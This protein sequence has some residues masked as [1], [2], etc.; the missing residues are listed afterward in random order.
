MKRRLIIPLV[1]LILLS[2]IR[3][4]Q[5]S[6]NPVRARSG[7]V[8]TSNEVASRVGVEILRHGG[9]AIDAAVAVGL[10][11]AVTFPDAGNL[12]GGGFMLVH[13]ADGRN[14]AIDYREV[15]PANARP[16]MY[17]DDRGNPIPDSSTVGYRAAGV[18]GTV[19]GFALALQKYGTMRWE[20]VVEPARKLAMDGF[21]ITPWL[22]ENLRNNSKLLE[23]FPVSRRIFLKEGKYYEE[24]EVFKQPE[25]A[26][27]LERLKKE[28]PREFYEGRTAHLIA[29]DMK[30]NGGAITLQDLK[31]YKPVERTPLQG[32]YRGYDIL[33]MPPPSS[34]GVALLEI[35]NVLEQYDLSAMGDQSSTKYHVLIETMRRAFADRAEFMG[36]PDFVKVPV[37]GLTSKRYAAEIKQAIDISKATPSSKVGHGNPPANESRETTHFTVVD[38]KGNAV[39]N[40]FTLNGWFGSGATISEAGFLLNNEMDDFAV[41]PGATNAYGLVQ[42]QNNAIAAGKRPLSSM[43]PTIVLK[44]GKMYLAI[45]SPGGPTI[46]NQIV[47]VIVNIIDHGMNLQQAINAPR[48]HHQWLPDVIVYEPYAIA[49]DV[50]ASL[51]AKGHAFADQGFYLGDVQ[52][53]MIDLKTGERLG[54]SDPRGPGGHALGY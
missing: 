43:T 42:G 35:L 14:T 47:E 27:T 15:A 2:H 49:Q 46:I 37:Q 31:D 3:P 11:L 30:A 50:L 32:T 10:A 9:N 34:G 8:A 1:T 40:T 5:A 20:D 24:G 54:G 6:I 26:R 44:D 52:A 19:A 29:E 53:V 25:L 28:G 7:M 12:G 41:K 17:L 45:G 22:A 36:D 33:T 38:A 4:A 13:L 18:P 39:S 23:R 21:S 48:L 16:D 51:K